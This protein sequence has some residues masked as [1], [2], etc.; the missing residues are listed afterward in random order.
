MAELNRLEAAQ[1]EVE[2]VQGILRD[3]MGKVLSIMEKWDYWMNEEI[4]GA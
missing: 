3:N 4:W 1:A 2:E